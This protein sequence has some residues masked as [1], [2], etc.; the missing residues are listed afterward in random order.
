MYIRGTVCAC[1]SEAPNL[2]SLRIVIS[3]FSLPAPFRVQRWLCFTQFIYSGVE[4]MTGAAK[5]TSQPREHSYELLLRRT[6]VH[7]YT[8][9][10]CLMGEE[11]VPHGVGSAFQGHLLRFK[12]PGSINQLRIQPTM[13]E[14]A[15][16]VFGFPW[17]FSFSGGC[18]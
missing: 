6:Y 9:L 8:R 5:T 18:F 16:L 17:S 2:L 12:E 3:G 14:G 15:C 7:R 1:I 10:A 11:L 4:S 13:G